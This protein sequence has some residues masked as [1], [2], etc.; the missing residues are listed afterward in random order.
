VT[1]LRR[2]FVTLRAHVGRGAQH[3]PG[4]A[5]L[6]PF[7]RCHSVTRLVTPIFGHREKQKTDFQAEA[8]GAVVESAYR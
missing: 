1:I 7:P 5:C 6:T 4:Q 8:L 3:D 2:Q